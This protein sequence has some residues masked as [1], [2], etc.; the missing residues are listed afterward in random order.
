MSITLDD[1]GNIVDFDCDC[2]ISLNEGYH[3][4][5][6][7]DVLT[8]NPGTVLSGG[9]SAFQQNPTGSQD[10]IVEDCNGND[11]I[12]VSGNPISYVKLDMLEITANLQELIVMEMVIQVRMMV[13]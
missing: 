13:L 12:D 8:K 10:G 3:G 5:R 9:Y 1:S 6:C 2:D 7:E 4:T 11:V